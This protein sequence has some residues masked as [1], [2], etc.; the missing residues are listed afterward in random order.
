VEKLVEKI[1]LL[2]P[3]IVLLG[4]DYVDAAAGFPY[5]NQLLHA[6]SARRHVFAIAGNH[7]R[8]T[9]LDKIEAMVVSHH[10]AWIEG[11]SIDLDLFDKKVCI[12]GN[13][14][15]KAAKQVD[16]AILCLHIPIDIEPYQH[17]YDIVFAGH[18]HGS[19]LVFWE[20]DK[21]LFPGRLFY[22]WNLRKTQIGSCHYFIGK[23]LG[24][25]L[26]IR[27]NCEKEIIFLN[28]GT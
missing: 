17:G 1:D 5:F 2:N 20:T 27:Y 25:T 13:R 24:D 23:G 9:G 28:L 19:Q 15:T 26:P 7:D 4:G 14:P 3:T 12:E 8:W 6:L 11:K 22:R 10:I 18:L 21:G 16:V